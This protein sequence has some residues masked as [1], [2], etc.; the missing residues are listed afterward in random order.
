[1]KKKPIISDDITLTILEA[2]A[3]LL[4]IPVAM[5]MRII[6]KLTNLVWRNAKIVSYTPAFCA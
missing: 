6:S 1:V 5:A 4:F 2:H 3:F